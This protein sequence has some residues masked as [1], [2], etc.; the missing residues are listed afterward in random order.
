MLSHTAANSPARVLI[1][2]DQPGNLLALQAVLQELDAELVPARS[3]AEALARTLDEDFAAILMD[4]RMPDMDGI[5][6]ARLIRSRVRSRNTP[7]LFVTATEPPDA[8]IEDAYALGAVDF[9]TK[10]LQPRVLKGKVAF[11]IALHRSREELREAE[12]SAVNERAFL[13]AVLD[14]VEDGIVACDAEGRLTLFNRATRELHGLAPSD[15]PR[16]EWP[17]R[18]G[19]MRPDGSG[20]LPPEEIPLA[21]ALAGE[22]VRNAEISV[23]GADGRCHVLWASGQPLYDARTGRQLGAVVSMHDVTAQR[24]AAAARELAVREQARREAAEAAAERL[25]ASEERYRTLFDSME[26]GFCVIE[27][28]FDEQERAVDYL[29]LEANPTYTRHTGLRDVT[30]RRMSALGRTIDPHWLEVYG[31]VA[32][33]GQPQRLLH[34]LPGVPRWFDVSITRV[35]EPR[36]RRVALIAS[37]VTERVQAEEVLRR[38]ADELAETNRRKTEFLATLAHELRNPLAPLRNGLHLLRRARDDAAR[39]RT[40]DMM[41]RQLGHMVR[42]IDDLLDIARVS[43]GKVELKRTRSTLRQLVHS[44]VETAQPLLDAARH[45]LVMDLPAESVWLDVDPTRIAQ[46]LFNLLSNAAKYTPDG[47][48][49]RLHAHVEGRQVVLSVH[50]DGI[51]IPEQDLTR[52]FQMFTQFGR[53]SLHAPGGLGIG[54]ALVQSLV[55]LHGGRIEAESPGPGRGSTFTLRLP[56]AADEAASAAADEGASRAGTGGLNVLVVD[57]NEDAAESLATILQ[58]DG[59]VARV[60]HDGQQ[61]LALAREFGPQVVFLDIGMPGMDG[62]QVAR[63]LGQQHPGASRPVL[64]AL[65][66]WGA[67]DDLAR[68]RDAGF[69]H[70]LTKPAEIADVERLLDG[71]RAGL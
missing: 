69:D 70:H 23:D 11:F 18:Y 33:T 10:P 4:L 13:A 52:V 39:L 27:I 71:L 12:R 41:D 53:E 45:T 2:D 37:E 31:Q 34:H 9:L 30:G 19:L 59:H 8:D 3:G 61:A 49:I 38:L 63:T 47:G 1:V 40:W 28:L 5:E 64:V 68:A 42:L 55:D 26:E 36:A 22:R 21:R 46:V 6:A 65:T 7:I 50:D 58:M 20:P 62:Y 43:T 66:G 56:L 32:T 16:Q 29:Y 57:D 14:A 67:P 15:M 54:L 17:Q 44:A 24:E 60:A 51:G 35:G 48:H 25:R